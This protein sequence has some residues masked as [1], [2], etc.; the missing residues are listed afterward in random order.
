MEENKLR[1]S[2][3]KN[4]PWSLSFSNDGQLLAVGLGNGSIELWSIQKDKETKQPFMRLPSFRDGAVTSISFSADG[5][6]P[7]ASYFNGVVR[8]WDIQ[9][10]EKKSLNS[11]PD[12]DR[13]LE[14]GCKWLDDYHKTEHINPRAH[15]DRNNTQDSDKTN[16]V[17][18]YCDSLR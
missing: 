9:E 6:N 13:L 1:S 14:R 15:Q 3:N 5:K 12:L 2:D 17:K 11:D 10:D 7:M 18:K 8:F 4:I 16:N